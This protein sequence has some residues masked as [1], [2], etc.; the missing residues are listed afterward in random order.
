MKKEHNNVHKRLI[1]RVEQR[2]VCMY[3]KWNVKG[4]NATPGV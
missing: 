3:M 1:D 2:I 4:D